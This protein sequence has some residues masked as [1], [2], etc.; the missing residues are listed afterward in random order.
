M[1]SREVPIG[2]IKKVTL[3]SKG[4]EGEAVSTG[5]CRGRTF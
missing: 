4:E 3:E 1:I 5:L 2:L